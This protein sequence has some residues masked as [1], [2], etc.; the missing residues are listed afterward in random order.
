MARRIQNKLKA[1]GGFQLKSFLTF[2]PPF[3]VLGLF[4]VNGNVPLNMEKVN[5]QT[6]WV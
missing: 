1:R 3:L 2:S 6:L 4:V 5:I